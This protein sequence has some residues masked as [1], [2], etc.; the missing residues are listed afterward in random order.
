MDYDKIFLVAG[1]D[2]RQVY[3]AEIL[4]KTNKVYAIGFDKNLIISDR[5][6]AIDSLMS[7]GERVDYLVLPL[8]ASSDGVQV[9]APFSKHSIPLDNL[10]SILNDGAV[11][12]GGRISPMVKGVFDRRGIDVVD[13]FDREE[14]SVLNAVPTAEGA[15]QIAMEELPATI[16]GQR[17]LITGFG[18]ITKV[19]VKILKGL[20][21]EVTIAARKYSDLAWAEIYGCKA[22]HIARLND[23][24]G[25]FGVVFNTVPAILLDESRLAMLKEDCLVI[26]LASKPG[27]VD[28]DTAGKIGVKTIWA[29][30]LPGKVAPITSGEMIAH[31]VLNILSERGGEN[32]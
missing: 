27:G 6:A 25:G 11:V 29:L 32:G 28:F 3:L 30:S 13:Y 22:V 15:V 2:L 19:L 5:V 21:A 26:D 16:Y 17:I 4:A 10:T 24:I 1:G 14:L 31:T 20:G 7:L 18:R 9:N 23:V 8:P 12:F